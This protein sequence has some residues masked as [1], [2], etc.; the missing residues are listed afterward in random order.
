MNKSDILRLAQEAGLDVTQ[1]DVIAGSIHGADI[2]TE[3]LA[4]FAELVAAGERE[5]ARN[6]EREG[7]ACFLEALG[8]SDLAGQVLAA[9]TRKI[10]Q[11]R[12][13]QAIDAF[14][15]RRGR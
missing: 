13:N 11:E 6:D 15:A 4:R 10:N 9:M 7:I 3:E 8:Y 12:R 14:L 5:D 1:I 2:I